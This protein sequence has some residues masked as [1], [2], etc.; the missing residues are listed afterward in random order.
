MEPLW[1]ALAFAFGFVARQVGLPPLVGFLVAGF[2][3]HGLGFER[4]PTLTAIADLGVTLLLFTIGLKLDPR[5]LL[6]PVIWGVAG[7][8]MAVVTAGF[9]VLLFGL[10][11][12]GV[13]ILASLD[14]GTAVLVA[15]AL[16][17][18]STVFA[19]KVLDDKQSSESLYGRIAIGVLIIQDIAAA[20]FLAVSKGTVPSPWAL[21]WVIGLIAL[22]PV[23]MLILDRS[24]HG[25]LLL[26]YGLLL[27]LG[28]GYAGAEMVGVKGD[29]GAI[30][31]GALM[32]PHKR[33]DE[34]YKGLMSLKDLLLVGFFLDVG[35]RGIP[36]LPA[37]GL[38]GLL[39]LLVPLKMVL[40]MV[41]FTMF[42]ARAR[43][44]AMGGFALANFSEFGLIVAAVSVG[45]GLLEE[46]WIGIVAVAVSAS[47]TLAA[48]LNRYSNRIYDRIG[49]WVQRMETE[50]MLPEEVPLPTEDTDV[51]VVGMG[52]MGTAAYDRMS[53][54]FGRSVLGIEQNHETVARH[55]AE[56]RR[57][58]Y[59]DATEED[60]LRRAVGEHLSIGLL[61]LPSHR[62]NLRVAKLF[63]ACQP[64][65]TL[66]ALAY[67][68]DEAAELRALGVQTFNTFAE[69]GFGM[70]D[71]V[72]EQMPENEPPTG[73]S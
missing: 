56:G 43:T 63:R 27:G 55:E 61:A 68:E 21:A 44:A 66:A 28:L 37:L 54:R 32:A 67:F 42:R 36:D 60:L 46:R 50:A 8:H 15:F 49:H 71:H 64:T 26:V 18:S 11:L 7:S 16:S 22:R 65:A 3:L 10:G 70:V 53:Q 17:F 6:R 34:M 35:M 51:V 31:V 24:G 62:A 73:A 9:G 38:T 41:L 33:A 12:A 19:V 20:V 4:G 59:G 47:L 13:P 5:S 25:E 30:F 1:L 23:L 52:R 45:G 14:F 58:I 40:F 69:A 72:M 48:P 57:V 39:L 29:L 2:A